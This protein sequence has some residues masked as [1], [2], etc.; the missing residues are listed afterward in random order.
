LFTNPITFAVSS[1][2]VGGLGGFS[3][4]LSS[5]STGMQAPAAMLNPSNVSGSPN[6]NHWRENNDNPCKDARDIFP[7]TY[8]RRV[9]ITFAAHDQRNETTERGVIAIG[10][11]CL[12]DGRRAGVIPYR[13][14]VVETCRTAC[15]VRS[16]VARFG[17]MQQQQRH[18]KHDRCGDGG[19]T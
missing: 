4:G 3:G 14:D 7:P 2:A 10:R 1:C 11:R 17:R 12:R 13:R 15:P 18:A 16:P 9:S 19:C 8:C 5:A 6:E